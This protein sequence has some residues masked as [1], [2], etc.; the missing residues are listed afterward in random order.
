MF[1]SFVV[2]CYLI[3]IFLKV[4]LIILLIKPFPSRFQAKTAKD[5][6]TAINSLEPLRFL[7]ENVENGNYPEDIHEEEGKVPDYYVCRGVLIRKS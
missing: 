7:P 3:I 5:I 2:R 1:I 4:K 6:I